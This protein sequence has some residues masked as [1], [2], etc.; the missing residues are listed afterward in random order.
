MTRDE[1]ALTLIDALGMSDQKVTELTLNFRANSIPRMSVTLEIDAI[2]VDTQL[3]EFH[4]SLR[5]FELTPIDG[6]DEEEQ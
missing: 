2:N 3:H 6:L 1:L 4:E 5:H